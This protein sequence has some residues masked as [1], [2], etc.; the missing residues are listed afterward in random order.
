M[1]FKMSLA[2]L[3]FSFDVHAKQQQLKP[4]C[5]TFAMNVKFNQALKLWNICIFL[6]NADIAVVGIV[7]ESHCCGILWHNVFVGKNA[8]L[9]YVQNP[10]VGVKLMSK[11]RSFPIRALNTRSFCSIVV[12]K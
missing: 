5:N 4:H 8:N 10:K 11:G 7:K 1:A 3:T 6:Q 2:K 9:I 12:V